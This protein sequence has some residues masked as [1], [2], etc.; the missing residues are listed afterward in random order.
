MEAIVG[1]LHS[2][3][4]SIIV[5]IAITVL[6]VY[7]ERR[8]FRRIKQ[9]RNSVYVG[10]LQSMLEAIIVI[11]GIVS[12]TRLSTPAD[13]FVNTMVLSS[14]VIVVVLGFI[15]QEGTKNIIHGFFISIY[16]PFEVG[17]RI[18]VT[19]D[20]RV[21]DGYVESL[22]LRHTIVR[23][24]ITNV[25]EI[26]PNSVLDGL[27]IQNFSRLG[28]EANIPNVGTDEN[29]NLLSTDKLIIEVT[30]ESDIDRAKEIMRN[31]VTSHP[32]FVDYRKDKSKPFPVYMEDLGLNG[33]DLSI[34]VAG[35]D[36]AAVYVEMCE[37]RE[38]IYREFNKAG[39]EFAYAHM[40]ILGDLNITKHKEA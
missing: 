30:Y 35:E 10:F 29:G 14:S 32:L 18:K 36:R 1:F 28:H 26:I 7:V 19:A 11:M 4:F 9:I 5:T 3:L 13:T 39:V 6:I 25:T 20:G 38:N 33:I 37:D 27:S 24:V 34:L 40:Q 22:T 16:R 31:V 15:F 2:K 21:I 17:D 8:V 12:L 23:N